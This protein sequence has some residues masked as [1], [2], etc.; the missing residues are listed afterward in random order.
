MNEIKTLFPSPRTI[1]HRITKKYSTCDIPYLPTVKE[2]SQTS[3]N[4]ST[5]MTT[6][7]PKVN[8]SL[9]ETGQDAAT[10]LFELLHSK[11]STNDTKVEPG[12]P[13]VYTDWLFTLEGE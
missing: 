13:K 12:V 5:K 6:A 4:P 1:Y 7:A 2:S 9:G 11:K 3:Q 10:Q 8:S